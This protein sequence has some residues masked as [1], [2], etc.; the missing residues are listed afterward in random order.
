MVF[1]SPRVFTSIVQVYNYKFFNNADLYGILANTDRETVETMVDAVTTARRDIQGPKLDQTIRHYVLLWCA[2]HFQC[3]PMRRV[4]TFYRF[5]SSL[6]PR[7]QLAAY[8]RCDT[9]TI[10]SRLQN[11]TNYMILG[12]NDYLPNYPTNLPALLDDN[13]ADM[14]GVRWS[15]PLPDLSRINQ[16]MAKMR[17]CDNTPAIVKQSAMLILDGSGTVV[18][19]PGDASKGAKA[20]CFWK[21]ENQLRWYV[22]VD[23]TGYIHF[24]SP[25]YWGKI[26]DTSA[27]TF[28]GFY[29]Y[30]LQNRSRTCNLRF[31]NSWVDKRVTKTG[32][33]VVD[34]EELHFALGGDKGYYNVQPIGDT[35]IVL[36][37]TAVDQALDD[38]ADDSDADD[39][40]APKKKRTVGRRKKQ[41]VENLRKNHKNC[42]LDPFFASHRSVVE[43]TIGW[44]K[45]T[46]PFID[47]PIT[48][49]QA[50]SLAGALIVACALHNKEMHKNPHLH[51][52]AS[53][54]DADEAEDEAVELQPDL[55]GAAQI[56]Q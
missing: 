1:G 54:A 31:P 4:S 28:T 15:G 43:R 20:W 5:F 46:V 21:K 13:T 19:K 44:L 17:Q 48:A 23:A 30:G 26:D 49:A 27:L 52:S 11:Y 29:E 18:R 33:V 6:T 40:R 32:K 42:V 39:E 22:A 37:E 10:R 34:G 36:T 24:V 25:V 41:M 12:L 2:V 14:S 51:V 47:G 16:A 53:A 56:D 35:V 38:E 55:N 3:I 50:D 9:T 45:S 7:S 8:Y